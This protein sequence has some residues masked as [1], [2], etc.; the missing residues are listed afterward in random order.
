VYNQD[1]EALAEVLK[2]Y[3]LPLKGFFCH[4]EAL[5]DRWISGC[6]VIFHVFFWESEIVLA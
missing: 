2:E 6:N 4:H 3:L 5:V 1:K